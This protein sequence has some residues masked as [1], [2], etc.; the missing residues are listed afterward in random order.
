[1]TSNKADMTMNILPL[2]ET[3]I[4]EEFCQIIEGR[5]Q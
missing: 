4:E 2:E 1:M 5:S 3:S